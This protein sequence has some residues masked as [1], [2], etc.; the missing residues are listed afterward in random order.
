[1]KLINISG[2]SREYSKK[3]FIYEFPFPSSIPTNVPDE[4]GKLLLAT[5]NFKK[6]EVNKNAI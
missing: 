5:G 3:G 1:M 4:I 2:Q 6:K